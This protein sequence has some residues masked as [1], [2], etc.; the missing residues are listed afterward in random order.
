M[1]RKVFVLC[2]LTFAFSCSNRTAATPE[3]EAE[4]LARTEFTERIENF[5]EY[6][7]LKAGQPS[8]FRIHLSDL[9]DGTPVEGAE[10]V[11]SVRAPGSGTPMTSTTAQIAKVA[12]IYVAEL[13][14]PRAGQYDVEF[15]IKNSKL[16]ERMLLNDFRVE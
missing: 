6:A 2:L 13:T 15:R 14:V 9:L 16:D 4:A 5:F 1:N 11:L 12:G 7:P 10:V 3:Q 8:Q